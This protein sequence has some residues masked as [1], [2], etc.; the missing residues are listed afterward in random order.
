MKTYFETGVLE[1]RPP[2]EVVCQ[3]IMR[4][5]RMQ[6]EWKGEKRGMMEMRTHV[7]S[8]TGGYPHSGALRRAM[9]EI[10]TLEELQHLLGV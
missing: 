2:F 6:V 4:H 5:A 10:E 1:E 9:N 3:T 8:Y 7:A